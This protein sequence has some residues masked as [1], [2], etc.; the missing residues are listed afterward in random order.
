MADN[1][2]PQVHLTCPVV[3][4]LFQDLISGNRTTRVR[5]DDGKER[6]F[7]R[8]TPWRVR[9]PNSFPLPVTYS[10]LE[11]SGKVT[12]WAHM[13]LHGSGGPPEPG[14]A[15]LAVDI[16]LL[17]HYTTANEGASPGT[18]VDEFKPFK[19]R[20]DDQNMHAIWYAFC[21]GRGD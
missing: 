9:P 16:V 19:Y 12:G 15:Q 20:E 7:S 5:L 14:Q 1:D 11:P 6:I 17:G 8:R 21:R 13:A 3:A 18:V 2:D 4:P 10:I